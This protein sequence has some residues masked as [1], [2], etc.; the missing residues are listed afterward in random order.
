MSEFVDVAPMKYGKCQTLGTTR[1]GTYTPFLA[2]RTYS[3]TG[4]NIRFEERVVPVFPYSDSR[5]KMLS[6]AAGLKSAANP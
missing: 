2:E 6:K 3:I 4:S 1:G 5:Q